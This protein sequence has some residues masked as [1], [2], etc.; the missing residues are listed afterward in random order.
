[1]KTPAWLV[2]LTMAA[3]F[4]EMN[5]NPS[6]NSPSVQVANKFREAKHFY[7]AA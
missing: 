5:Y 4:K 7:E 6:H 1:V 2:A 3:F